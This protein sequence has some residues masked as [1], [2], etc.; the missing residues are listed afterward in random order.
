MK[1]SE[2]LKLAKAQLWQGPQREW[3]GTKYK[4]VCACI[5]EVDK[6][7]HA[8]QVATQV[9]ALRLGIE[10]SIR[11][12]SSVISWLAEQLGVDSDTITFQERQDYRHR[13]LD[14]MIAECE[15][16]GN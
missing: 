13:W 7:P 14:H 6:L 1:D 5:W 4:G 12:H 11:P 9:A 2:I 10:K 16:K 15:A 8:T 3:L